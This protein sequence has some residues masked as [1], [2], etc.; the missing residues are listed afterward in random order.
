M[1]INEIYNYF[2]GLYR[3][4]KKGQSLKPTLFN[5]VIQ[6]VNEELF[7]DYARVFEANRVLTDALRPFLTVS[8]PISVTNGYA[9]LPTDYAYLSQFCGWETKNGEEYK[10]WGIEVDDKEWSQLLTSTL[11]TPT[12]SEPFGRLLGNYLEVTPSTVKRIVLIYLRKP[13]TPVFEYD[14]DSNNNIVYDENESVDFEYNMTCTNELLQRIAQKLAVRL[15][16][17][18][19]AQMNTPQQQQQQ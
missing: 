11:I 14:T 13:A 7:N 3:L 6:S 4:N 8:F 5:S 12:K 2:D 1:T 15:E 9:T 10:Y 18:L 16:D 19:L 17:R